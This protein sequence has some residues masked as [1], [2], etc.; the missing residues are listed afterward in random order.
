[1]QSMTVSPAIFTGDKTSSRTNDCSEFC[2]C[3]I[4]KAPTS[5]LKPKPLTDS[6]GEYCQCDRDIPSSA[7]KVN[8]ATLTEYCTCDHES[9]AITTRDKVKVRSS[10]PSL[11]KFSGPFLTKEMFMDDAPSTAAKPTAKSMAER[12]SSEI[13]KLEKQLAELKTQ[14][15]EMQKAEQAQQAQ[16]TEGE[17]NAKTEPEPSANCVF[18][19]T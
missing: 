14:Q 16:Q 10:I 18:R 6:H 11:A 5:S 13:L 1:M 9:A 4:T 12:H 2:Q 7:T 19:V 17:V 8:A 3:D 15:I